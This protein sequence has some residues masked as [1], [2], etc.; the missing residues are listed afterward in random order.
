[1]T[2]TEHAAAHGC[3]I[4]FCPRRI[5]NKYCH[6]NTRTHKPTFRETTSAYFRAS[7][8]WFLFLYAHTSS[9]APFVRSI[10]QLFK[11]DI[12]VRR[13]RPA[14]MDDVGS[15]AVCT[16]LELT[17]ATSKW[18]LCEFLSA[19][20]S[21]RVDYRSDVPVC[22]TTSTHDN[23]DVPFV[24]LDRD[25]FRSLVK[26]RFPEPAHMR[27]LKQQFLDLPDSSHCFT[28]GNSPLSN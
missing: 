28:T 9:V 20:S 25:W 11:V 27:I 8:S 26:M 23:G 18:T 1:M 22:C 19:C 2:A 7:F 15:S 12:F 6:T 13:S 3:P 10:L 5:L 21:V 17:T 14:V 4:I 24:G 16:V